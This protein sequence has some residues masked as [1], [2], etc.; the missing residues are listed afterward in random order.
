MMAPQE[1]SPVGGRVFVSDPLAGEVHVVFRADKPI[2]I[3]SEAC[4]QPLALGIEG[5]PPVDNLPSNAG[6]HAL[7]PVSAMPSIKLRWA[8]KKS[9]ITGK[10]TSV[11]AAIM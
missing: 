10:I 8:M 6:S 7:V 5:L 4:R 2:G 3:D 1:P 11:L 9:V